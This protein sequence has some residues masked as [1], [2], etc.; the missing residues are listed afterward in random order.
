MLTPRPQCQTR[1]AR[2][3]AAKGLENDILGANQF[4][5]ILIDSKRVAESRLVRMFCLE[6]T[7]DQTRRGSEMSRVQRLRAEVALR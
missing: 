5:Y 4:E 2:V 6:K 3:H 1:A 7:L